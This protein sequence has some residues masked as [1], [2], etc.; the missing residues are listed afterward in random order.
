MPEVGLNSSCLR[1]RI[2]TE[3]ELNIGSELSVVP[4]S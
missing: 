3:M 2:K 4:Q 1:T